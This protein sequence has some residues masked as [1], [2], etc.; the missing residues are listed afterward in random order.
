VTLSQDSSVART[1]LTV[2]HPI[3]AFGRDPENLGRMLAL[4]D[5]VIWGALSM[6]AEASD[7]VVAGLA[8]RLRDRKFYKAIDVRKLVR[9]ELLSLSNGIESEDR[10]AELDL[11]IDRTCAEVG[12]KISRMR[13]PRDELPA[14]LWDE[15]EREP[16]KTLEESK[17]PLNQIRVRTQEGELV[18]LRRLSPAVRSVKAF[19]LNRAYVQDERGESAKLV[20]RWIG[21]GVRNAARH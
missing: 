18:D 15:A 4:D 2:R 8:K 11:L 6:L 5:A 9:A 17:G 10:S 7:P 20:E 19:H 12:G 16:Y 14:I 13:G 3:V 1:G 21:E